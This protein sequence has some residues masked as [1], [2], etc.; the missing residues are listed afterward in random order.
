MYD[1]NIIIQNKNKLPIILDFGLSYNTKKIF[2]NKTI[3]I[4]IINK[5]YFTYKP[6]HYN[7]LHEKNFINF[8]I[9]NT[10]ESS[11]P[12]YENYFSLVQD[13]KKEND[14]TIENILICV[15]NFQKIFNNYY[16]KIYNL[17]SQKEFDY[18]LNS[19]EK[20]Y[21]KFADKN[22]YPTYY[23]ILSELLPNVF[24]YTDIY[25]IIFLYLEIFNNNNNNNNNN[26]VKNPIIKILHLFFKKIIL[27]DPVERINPKQLKS[28][29]NKIFNFIKKADPNDEKNEINNFIIEFDNNLKKIGI[30]YDIFYNKTYAYIDFHEIFKNKLKSLKKLNFNF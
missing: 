26:K 24:I 17:F 9:N 6:N 18:F 27:A 8:I 5:F 20:Y 3:D 19:F 12:D 23:E 30:N 16:N 1:R 21:T 22:K 15:S 10:F 13:V 28:M 11:D 7:H 4:K 25:S 2:H 14:L 29:L